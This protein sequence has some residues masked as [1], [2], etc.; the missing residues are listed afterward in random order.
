A[1]EVASWPHSARIASGEPARLPAARA[2][3]RGPLRVLL[4]LHVAY[5]GGVWETTKDLIQD[6]LAINRERRLLDL[7]LGLHPDQI[8]VASLASLEGLR[9]ERLR[10]CPV[11]NR[12]AAAVL[13]REPATIGGTGGGHS[14]F[15]GPAAGAAAAD[16]DAWLAL[17]DRFPL[18]LLPLRPYGVFVY[19]MIQLRVPEVFPAWFF[20]EMKRG[21]SPTIRAADAVIVTSPPTRADVMETYGVEP[22]RARL[23]PV[24]HSPR[25]RFASLAPERVARVREPFILNV[26][27]ATPH[28]GARVLLEAMA[29][30][31][32]TERW[33]DVR[34]A[35][36]GF[37]TERFSPRHVR[38]FT[39]PYIREI[40]RLVTSL[41][42]VE[43][44]DVVFLGFVSDPQL[45]DLFERSSAVINAARFDNGA[46]SLCEAAYFGRPAVTTRYAA[47]LYLCERFGVPV[48][49]F[50][51]GDAAGCARALE[52]ALQRGKLAPEEVER[53][54]T[55]LD[56]PELGSRRYGERVYEILVELAAKGREGAGRSPGMVNSRQ[57]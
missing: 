54:R 14:F 48:E 47:A 7:T 43:D 52:S 10:V 44:R 15:S 24:S 56:D 42:L 40:S 51:P 55:R 39:S 2:E 37:A 35:M 31:K 9:I 45:R 36:C 6:L 17:V 21:M 23:V 33:R 3:R 53:V 50:E 29:L 16:A 4:F 26:A 19:D 11:T 18:P 34:L 32:K 41:G 46:F 49:T 28:K 13:G 25:R 5:H 30:L 57:A 27:N 38:R 20:D 12:Q 22:A 8:D 1:R